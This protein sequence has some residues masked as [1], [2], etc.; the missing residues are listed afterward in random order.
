MFPDRIGKESREAAC[1]GVYLCGG[2]GSAYKES[3]SRMNLSV[4]ASCRGG[5]GKGIDCV[6]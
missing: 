3:K 5:A 6:K 4:L 2:V 1:T